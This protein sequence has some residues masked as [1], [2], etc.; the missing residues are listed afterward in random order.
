MAARIKVALLVEAGIFAAAASAH[1]AAQADAK[2]ELA[3]TKKVVKERAEEPV[4]PLLTSVT[5]QDPDVRWLTGTHEA[6]GRSY[7]IQEGYEELLWWLQLPALCSMAQRSTLGNATLAELRS[8]A[9]KIAATISDATAEAAHAGYCLEDLLP[10]VT[11]ENE[12]DPAFD[13]TP[14]AEPVAP[15]ALNSVDLKA[16][17]PKS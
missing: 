15:D 4:N 1:D 7:F 14:D 6:S 13:A 11:S 3:V 2:V 9:S 17:R 8:D 5:W 10:V 12:L 16:K